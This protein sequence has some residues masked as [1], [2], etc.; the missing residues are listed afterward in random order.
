VLELDEFTYQNT[1]VDV[2][3]TPVGGSLTTTVLQGLEVWEPGQSGGTYII[4]LCSLTTPTFWQGGNQVSIGFDF[5]ETGGRCTINGDC[6][7]PPTST[8]TPTPVGPT[9]TPTPTVTP[10]GNCIVWSESVQTG[11]QDGCGGFQKTLTTITVQL[12]DGSGNPIN[13]TE[14]IDV[15]W[16]ATYS[17]ELGTSSVTVGA[18]IPIGYSYGTTN[19]SS[20][21]YE[22]GPFS[23]QCTPES[24]TLDNTACPT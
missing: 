10:G 6:V 23:G 17:N 8:P 9:P 15:V 21:T 7:I 5:T 20:S 2:K 1:S 16:N 13:A 24:T 12:Q 18:Q 4:Y 22:I 11:L 14:I 19:Y 3:Y